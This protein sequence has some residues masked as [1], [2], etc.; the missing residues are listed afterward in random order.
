MLSTLILY[1]EVPEMT[2]SQ[3]QTITSTLICT[4]RHISVAIY[5][6]MN[7]YCTILSWVTKFS[8]FHDTKT[9]VNKRL[10]M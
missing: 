4:A 8:G 2:L 6:S 10:F 1:H 9:S 3:E 7:V 5:I